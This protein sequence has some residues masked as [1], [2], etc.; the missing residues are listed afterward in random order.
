M[1][2]LVLGTLP[3]FEKWKILSLHRCCEYVLVEKKCPKE[4]DHKINKYDF[5]ATD[6]D[7]NLNL[8]KRSLS[9]I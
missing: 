9:A 1:I 7:E 8:I 3:I 2:F 4:T 5:R 6:F